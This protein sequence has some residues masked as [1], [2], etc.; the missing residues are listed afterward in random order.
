MK[1]I[2]I[3]IFMITI[4][5]LTACGQ[6]GLPGIITT[7][8]AN[9]T[10]TTGVVCEFSGQPGP[11]VIVSSSTFTDYMDYFHVVGLVENTAAQ[12]M[13]YIEYNLQVKDAQGE[14][15][16]TDFDGNS[17]D[18]TTFYPLLGTL[19]PNETAPFDAYYTVP[20]GSVVSSCTISF[21]A[22]DSS[23]AERANVTAENVRMVI[24]EYNGNVFIFG[25]LV[26]TGS[27]PAHIDSLA[28]A[29]T[30]EDGNILSASYSLNLVEYLAPTGDPDGLDRGPFG[31]TIWGPVAGDPIPQVFI[32]A[33]VNEEL[34]TPQISGEVTNFYLDQYDYVHVVGTL[35]N[36]G[37]KQVSFSIQVSLLDAN[38]S[39]LDTD[40]LFPPVNLDPGMVIPFDQSSWYQI[41]FNDTD[42]AAI[43]GA[44][45]QIDPYWVM[46]SSSQQYVLSAADM[47]GA[48]E[49]DGE[50]K[51][52]GTVTNDTGGTLQVINVIAYLTD[53]NGKVV[54]TSYVLK[55]PASEVYAIGETESFEV[56]GM[57]PVDTDFS[58]LT[59]HTLVI[60]DAPSY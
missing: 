47:V 43:A 57:M 44:V 20:E 13:S 31:I 41:D 12:S 49:G 22:A 26:N 16:L 10:A 7:G 59:F 46:E 56:L 33:L 35:E 37:T 14:T 19:A 2:G 4:L 38:G 9:T 3:I 8:N 45:I 25:E 32:D 15:L 23:T 58:S 17:M 48:D 28:G 27:T 34:P 21:S 29:A 5:L 53:A 11:V 30:D 54:G 52:T 6:K 60:G 40:Y 1:R 24:D 42:K 55:Y 50:Y 36:N 18:S 51:V 39:I